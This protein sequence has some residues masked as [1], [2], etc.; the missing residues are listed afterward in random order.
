MFQLFQWRPNH[1]YSLN[2]QTD[3]LC[4]FSFFSPSDLNPIHETAVSPKEDS[5]TCAVSSCREP[6]NSLALW[7]WSD[8]ANL[9]L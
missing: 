7:P 5:L 2:P 3:T 9:P 6:V 1:P 8:L 4:L